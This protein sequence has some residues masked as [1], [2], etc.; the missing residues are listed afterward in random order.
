MKNKPIIIIGNGGHA[1][2]LTE[3]IISREKKIL[4]YTAPQEEENMFNLNYLGPDDIILKYHPDEVELVLGIGSVSPNP[5][6]ASIFHYFKEKGYLFANIIHPKATISSSCR[7][8][9][10]VQIMAGV[11]IQTN[12]Q[13]ADNTIINTGAILDHDSIIQEHVHIAPGTTISGGVQIGEGTHIGTGV[14]II[15]GITIGENCLIGAGSV[16]IKDIDD[17][18]KAYGI[19]AKEV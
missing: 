4:G 3:I 8:G 13:L 15:Q 7:V 19:P 5:V 18:I 2:V 11:V 16:V 1:R 10:G 14:K 17:N 12:A 9:Q 6:R